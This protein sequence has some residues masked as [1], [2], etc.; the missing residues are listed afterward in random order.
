M[1][2]TLQLPRKRK[3]PDAAPAEPRNHRHRDTSGPYENANTKYISMD[4]AKGYCE[5]YASEVNPDDSSDLHSPTVVGCVA[6]I[7]ARG[8]SSPSASP[9]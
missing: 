7:K 1:H 8:L 5:E 3:P 2:T 9:S 6:A 4:S